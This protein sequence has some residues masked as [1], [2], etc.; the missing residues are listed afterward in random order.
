MKVAISRAFRLRECPLGELPRIPRG[1]Y[2]TIDPQNRTPVIKASL[3]TIRA[4]KYNCK[5]ALSI[6]Q[7]VRSTVLPFTEIVF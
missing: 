6:S 2:S 5:L 1:S 4:G 3:E 7:I